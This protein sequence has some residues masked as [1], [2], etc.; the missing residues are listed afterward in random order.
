MANGVLGSNKEETSGYNKILG[1]IVEHSYN[2]AEVSRYEKLSHYVMKSIFFFPNF[3]SKPFKEAKSPNCN[4]YARSFPLC[5]LYCSMHFRWRSA[6]RLCSLLLSF[7]H[8]SLKFAQF[9]CSVFPE[10]E[11]CAI[12]TTELLLTYLLC[13]NLHL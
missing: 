4:G 1:T 13:V 5:A 7:P 8:Y 3:G 11:L 12:I 9:Q 6:T 2:Y 10:W